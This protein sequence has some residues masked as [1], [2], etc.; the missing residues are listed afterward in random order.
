MKFIELS[1]KENY[2]IKGEL[3]EAAYKGIYETERTIISEDV[4]TRD[5]IEKTGDILYKISLQINGQFHYLYYDDKRVRD[6]D[7]NSIAKA[8]G[9]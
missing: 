7:F 9:A 6:N 3:I 2:I 8:M 5:I 4:L 1:D